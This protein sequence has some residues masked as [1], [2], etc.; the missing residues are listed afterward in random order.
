[1][2]RSTPASSAAL[3]RSPVPRVEARRAFSGVRS[4]G[5]NRASPDAAA[6]SMN[7][8]RPPSSSSQSAVI[9]PAKR[10]RGLDLA[11]LG[12]ITECRGNGGQGSLAPIG[13]R[14]L[15]DLV[16]RTHAR[17]ARGDRRSHRDRVERTA[18]RVRGHDHAERS[19]AEV[20]HAPKDTRSPDGGTAPPGL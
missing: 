9:G 7:A 13:H 8:P 17:P 14:S 11:E 18:E 10:I 6:I 4:S 2:I 20:R 5:D 16:V 1:M 3:T 15:Q 12:G 19:S